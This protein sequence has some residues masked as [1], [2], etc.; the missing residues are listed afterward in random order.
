MKSNMRDLCIPLE[1]YAYE[2]EY[3]CALL[4]GLLEPLYK[5][6]GLKLTDETPEAA[7]DASTRPASLADALAA[8]SVASNSDDKQ[9]DEVK[10]ATTEQQ[11]E[12]DA[13]AAPTRPRVSKCY[14][15]VI[16]DMV[17]ALWSDLTT[18]CERKVKTKIDEKQQQVTA[19]ADAAQRLRVRAIR[20]LMDQCVRCFATR[21]RH[22]IRH[23][24]E[25]ALTLLSL[26]C[27][28][29]SADV[30]SLKAA[31]PSADKR[32]DVLLYE[33]SSMVNSV[34]VKLH[35]TYGYD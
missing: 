3:A 4:I 8:A 13:D 30:T 7:A 26:C 5:K 9:D 35:V 21:S 15:E 33:C 34:P 14:G 24:S 11:Q 1:E 12:D 27:A 19:R 20:L 16:N 25:D 29:P 32:H 31:A 18:A 10:T 28:S 23:T 22:W 2:Q 6:Y 17:H